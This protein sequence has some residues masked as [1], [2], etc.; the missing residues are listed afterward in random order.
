MLYG[1]RRIYSGNRRR[2]YP[3]TS[4]SPFCPR[5]YL[6]LHLLCSTMAS[7][8][9][10][11]RPGAP[12][13]AIGVDGWVEYEHECQFRR[14]AFD[15]GQWVGRRR[16]V[17]MNGREKKKRRESGWNKQERQRQK[18]GENERQK[19]RPPPVTLDGVLVRQSWKESARSSGQFLFLFFFG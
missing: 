4:E 7:S 13:Q 9:S 19:A 11:I 17:L 3:P 18:E 1:C 2:R 5:N 8:N 10:L 12:Q 16:R 15:W 14:F 6:C